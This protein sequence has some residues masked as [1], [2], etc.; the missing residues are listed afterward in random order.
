MKRVEMHLSFTADDEKA[1]KQ[2][3]GDL[4][5]GRT[6]ALDFVRFTFDSALIDGNSPKPD[7][8]HCGL[9]VYTEPDG[10]TRGLCHLCHLERCDLPNGDPFPCSEKS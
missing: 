6:Y 10:F 9:P 3:I 4:E 7:K 8:C 1:A 5:A 2:I